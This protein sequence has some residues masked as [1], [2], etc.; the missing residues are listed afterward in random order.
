[1]LQKITIT[2][3]LKDLVSL[4]AVRFLKTCNCNMKHSKQNHR[5][6]FSALQ[7][8]FVGFAEYVK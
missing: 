2:T 3:S 8:R 4:I 7:T 5:V 6:G 1:M